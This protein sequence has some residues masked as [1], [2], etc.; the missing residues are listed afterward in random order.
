MTEQET[1]ALWKSLV[2][3]QFKDQMVLMWT[4]RNWQHHG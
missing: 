1:L 3:N 2:E 4:E